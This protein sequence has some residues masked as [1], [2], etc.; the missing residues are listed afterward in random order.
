MKILERLGYRSPREQAS[1]PTSNG[2]R[3]GVER[4]SICVTARFSILTPA[5][6]RGADMETH[7]GR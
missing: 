5:R 6:D 1:A 3:G 4:R 7:S 2:S